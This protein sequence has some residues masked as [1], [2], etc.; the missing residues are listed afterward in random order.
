MF[1]LL[2]KY[3]PENVFSALDTYVCGFFIRI[4]YRVNVERE[5]IMILVNR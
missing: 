3:S 1:L 4:E 5:V 2:P